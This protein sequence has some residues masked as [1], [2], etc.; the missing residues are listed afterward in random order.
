MVVIASWDTMMKTGQLGMIQEALMVNL[1][2]P[3]DLE[4]QVAQ[5]GSLPGVPV[6]SW[7]MTRSDPCTKQYLALQQHKGK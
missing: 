5:L 3:L 7:P 2:F 4:M 6:L 1:S